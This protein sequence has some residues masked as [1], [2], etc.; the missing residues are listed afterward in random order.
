[1]YK[2]WKVVQKQYNGKTALQTTKINV[3][4]NVRLLVKEVSFNR[5]GLI[6]SLSFVVDIPKSTLF[7]I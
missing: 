7:D 1:M 2:I 6:R 3:N 5:R 4:K